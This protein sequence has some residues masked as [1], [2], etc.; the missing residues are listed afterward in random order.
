MMASRFLWYVAATAMFALAPAW[1]AVDTLRGT[2]DTED[3]T[4]Y[5]WANCNSE[6]SEEDCR[7]YNAGGITSL[8]VG[9]SGPG[10]ERRALLRLPGWDGTIPVILTAFMPV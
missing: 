1:G 6:V 3:C 9:L 4:I 8:P 10:Q 5:S 2:S 7:R